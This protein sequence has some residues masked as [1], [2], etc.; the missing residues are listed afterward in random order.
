MCERLLA[1]ALQQNDDLS[2]R[3][4][5]LEL[6]SRFALTGMTMRA[7]EQ[8]N[9]VSLDGSKP[10]L[11][12]INGWQA[13][14]SFG[15]REKTMDVFGAEYHATVIRNMVKERCDAGDTR[16]VAEITIDVEA[17]YQRALHAASGEGDG[18]SH[19]EDDTDGA[20]SSPGETRH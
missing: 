5:E 4:A 10:K 14:H 1:K 17:D 2:I 20:T 18:R 9:I 19:S 15:G 3:I 16:T 8:S 11:S 12:V 7:P 6:Q 13:F